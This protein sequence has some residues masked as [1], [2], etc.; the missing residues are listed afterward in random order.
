MGIGLTKN[1][2]NCS[3]TCICVSFRE[4]MN[5]INLNNLEVDLLTLLI[6]LDHPWG[7]KEQNIH[8]N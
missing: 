1:V 4:D 6:V 5:G 3:A 8:P 2:L 7:P